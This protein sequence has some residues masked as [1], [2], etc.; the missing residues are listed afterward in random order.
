[1]SCYLRHL[2]R[3]WFLEVAMGSKVSSGK[4]AA[5]S[6]VVQVVRPHTPLIK[7]PNREGMPK[8]NVQ[9]ALKLFLA[10]TPTPAAV[11]SAPSPPKPAGLVSR[12][13]G[14][15]DSIAIVKELPQRYRRRA[16]ALEEMDY[17]QRGGPE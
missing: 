8:A 5:A 12:L 3:K 14:T 17:I 7:F 6:R 10:N 13:P 16:L 2:N 9:E 11:H 4:M 1:M 15:P